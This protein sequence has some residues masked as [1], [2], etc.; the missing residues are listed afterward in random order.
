MGRAV[1]VLAVLATTAGA[2][3]PWEECAPL[4]APRYSGA[5]VC[6]L[7]RVYYLGGSEVGG[8]KTRTVFVYDPQADVWSVG[9]SMPEAR[10][11]FGAAAVDSSIYV[12]G[13]WGNSGVLLNSAWRYDV[14]SGTWSAI[15]TLP[16]RRASVFAA[17]TPGASGRVY[18]VGGWDGTHAHS[19]N[20]EFDPRTGHWRALAPLPTP[21][22]EGACAH[23]M[24]PIICVG[25]TS[26]GGTLLGTVECYDDW[27]DTWY[28]WVPSPVAR[29]GMAGV[30]AQGIRVLG[31]IGA[32]NTTL[33]ANWRIDYHG[34]WEEHEPLPAPR[35]FLASC[36]WVEDTFPN[37]SY[38][39][40]IGGQ[41]EGLQPSA[42]VW[43]WEPCLSVGSGASLLPPKSS[44]AR[45]LRPSERL[46]GPRDAAPEGLICEPGG[47]V[48][49]RVRAG[50]VCPALA[51]G[52]YLIQWRR[53]REVSPV[54]LVVVR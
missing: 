54:R 12:F 7:G 16:A 32:G 53:G 13:G 43:R 38:V 18:C 33:A 41:D 11:R 45:V 24:Y 31:G 4:P 15:E 36:F 25:G 1:A 35:R 48:V 19:D 52:T 28:T 34:V 49:A 2:Q 27:E 14:G 6:L 30:S 8:Q 22:C 40:A 5:A 29:M 17:A 20:F 21:R 51:S 37:R 10:H 50:D 39:Y 23:Y 26:D 44:W 3:W 46:P 9:D 47:R 42:S